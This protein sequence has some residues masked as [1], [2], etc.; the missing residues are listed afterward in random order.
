MGVHKNAPLSPLGRERLVRMVFGGQTPEAAGEAAAICPRTAR[1]WVG[2]YTSEGLAG[3]QDRNSRSHRLRQPTSEAVIERIEAL[4]ASDARRTSPTETPASA[5]RASARARQAVYAEVT[6]SGKA[7]VVAWTACLVLAIA[8]L[9]PLFP[10]YS[11]TCFRS[12][13][14]VHS[15]V[16]TATSLH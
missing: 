10:A 7:T 6:P 12:G 15:W 5:P 13:R 2:R 8:M 14:R 11:Q 9:L 4:A 16:I 1:K 3:L